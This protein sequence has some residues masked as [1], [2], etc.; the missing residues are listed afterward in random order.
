MG[1]VYIAGQVRTPIGKFGGMLSHLSA[2]ELGTIAAR[3]ALDRSGVPPATVNETFIG[4][5]RQ[6]GCGPNPA[7]QIAVGAGVP[8]ESPAT[9][10]NQACASGLRAIALAVDQV[11]LGRGDVY[12]V[13]GTESMSNTPYFLPRAR[14]GYRLGHGELVDGMYRD[15]FQC[16]IADQLMGRTAETLAEQYQITRQ[17]QDEYAAESQHRGANARERLKEE[18]VPIRVNNRKGGE[19]ALDYDEHVRPDTTVA[20]LSKLEPVFKDDGTVHAGNSSGITDGA[21]AAI[22]L[23]EDAARRLNVTPM[24]RIV[25]YSVVGVE[26]RIMGIGPV[27]AVQQLEKMTGIGLG[28]IDLIELNEAFAAQVLACHQELRFDL[29]TTNV[30]GGAIA[31][32]HPIGCTGTRITATLLHEMKRRKSQYGLATL[33]VSGGMGM[34]MLFEQV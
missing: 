23:S 32:G 26:A 11:R 25:D 10:V 1:D 33:C 17:S 7:R 30:N 9:T 29:A 15:G 18:I 31:L 14:W 3:A 19:V 21:A 16:P 22:V 13:G 12:L 4:H 2:V 27:P 8:Q 20:A 28:K 34:A 24:A 6:A 5:G